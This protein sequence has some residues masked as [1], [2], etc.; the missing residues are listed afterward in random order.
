MK[1]KKLLIIA[2][3]APYPLCFGGNQ[4]VFNAVDCLRKDLDIFYIYPGN[5][6]ETQGENYQVLNKLWENVTI[7]PYMK[8]S[9]TSNRYLFFKKVYKRL[10][11]YF[12]KDNVDYRLDQELKE[13]LEC[14]DEGFL[15]HIHDVILKYDIDIVQTE[16]NQALS[17]VN[18][19]PDNVKKV[20]VHH[21]I[22][23][24]RNELLLKK[25]GKEN[26]FL[27]KYKVEEMKTREI[28]LLNK[29]DTIITL[30]KNDK[31]KL[32]SAGVSTLIVPSFAIV[33]D[34]YTFKVP[35]KSTNIITFVGPEEHIPNKMGVEWFI[36]NCLESL[37]KKEP[38]IE[39]RIIGNWS[40]ATRKKYSSLSY[41]HFCGFVDD[42][43]AALQNTV[44]IVPIM[45]GSGIRM[46]ILEA[47]S[48]GVPFVT[49]TVGVEGIP[50]VNGEECIIADSPN[51]FVNG[52]LK[53][54]DLANCVKFT[55]KAFDKYKTLFSLESLKQSRKSVYE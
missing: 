39:F 44:M 24:V 53:M 35:T 32:E 46:K 11:S 31:K 54:F 1:K 7:L 14:L 2:G 3:W 29:Y 23:Y 38:T 51:E 27:Y 30:S 37:C 55:Q 41:I 10:C 49:T 45:I 17:L 33:Q 20:F 16:F 52:I 26:S 8:P 22:R 25:F 19:M 15:V 34:K 50:F 6:V 42:L 12:L 48:M 47:A 5:K 43:Q 18:T 9:N 28:A 40:E 21:E 13:E 4:A 36:N